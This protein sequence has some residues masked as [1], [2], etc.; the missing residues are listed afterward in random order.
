MFLTI[1]SIF[2]CKTV[3]VYAAQTTAQEEDESTD[4]EKNE[5]SD[6]GININGNLGDLGISITTNNDDDDAN[7]GLSTTLRIL[8]LLTVISLAPSILIMVTSFMRILI[9]FHFVRGA[10]GLQTTPPNQVLIG[11]ALFITFF[12]MEPVFAQVNNN[13][14]KPLEANEITYEEAI[15]LGMEP[16]REFMFGQIRNEKDLTLFCNLAGIETV[17]TLDDIPT[18]VLIPSFIISELRIA[19]YMGFIIYIPFLIIDMVVSATL[20]SMGMMM[21]P[22]TTIS[23]PFKILLFIVVDGWSLVIEQ[24][25]MT[26]Y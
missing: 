17:N 23:T 8:I 7:N 4:E 5:K 26:F 21:L 20:M 12:V 6:S 13:A 1:T 24:L 9:V 15:D 19:F 18:Y 3:P 2:I 10:L 16:I 22:P 14:I 11:L 25:V